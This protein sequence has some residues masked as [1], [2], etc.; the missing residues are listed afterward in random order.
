MVFHR[1]WKETPVVAVWRFVG[2]TGYPLRIVLDSVNGTPE[3]DVNA[4]LCGLEPRLL[5]SG[6]ADP[7][8][9]NSLVGA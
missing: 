2:G 7:V 6:Q 5:P 8:A 1:P 9:W 3:G 4:V